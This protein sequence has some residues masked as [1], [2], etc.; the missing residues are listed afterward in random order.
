TITKPITIR[1]RIAITLIVIGLVM[2]FVHFPV[3]G[4]D[5]ASFSNLWSHGGFFPKGV[6]GFLMSF[7]MVVFAFVGIEMV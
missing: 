7:Q 1:A 5:P 2:V 4:S 3:K 6:L